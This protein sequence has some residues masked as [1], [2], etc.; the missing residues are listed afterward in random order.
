MRHFEKRLI[1]LQRL[2]PGELRFCDRL[3]PLQLHHA[4]SR[5]DPADHQSL[6]QQICHDPRG[7]LGFRSEEHTSELQSPYDLVCRLLLEKKK[8]TRTIKENIRAI[9]AMS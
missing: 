2:N 8:N 3:S 4:R 9:N 1:G 5:D 7:H 6:A